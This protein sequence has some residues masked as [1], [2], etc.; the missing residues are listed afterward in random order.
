[1]A[2]ALLA[3]LRRM[4]TKP[5]E[6]FGV[7]RAAYGQVVWFWHPWLVSSPRRMCRPDR[8]RPHPSIRGRRWLN[9]FAHREEHEVRR[10]TIAQG[11]PDA[12]RWTCMLVCAFFVRNCTRDRGCSAHPV[13]PAPS[14][15]M[16][17]NE[18]ANLGQFMS[19]DSEIMSAVVAVER[20]S[21]TAVIASHRAARMRARC[22]APRSN[23]LSPCAA[24]RT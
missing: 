16:R 10:K 2:K 19:R 11:R 7:G 22:Q 20:A 18:D 14:F 5:V 17:A 15:S 6:T 21:I 24:R 9:E 4:G 1:D 8:A 13:F 23:P 12:L 3:R